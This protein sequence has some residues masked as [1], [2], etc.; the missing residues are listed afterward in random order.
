MLKRL[1]PED[2]HLLLNHGPV[3]LI[4][5]ADKKNNPNI[6]T[7]AWTGIVNSEPPLIAIGMGEQAYSLQSIKKSKEFVV[8]LP[9]RKLIKSVL[10]CGKISGKNRDKFSE[11]NLT[12]IKSKIVKS[13]KIKE[14]FAHIECRVANQY[15][16]G[17]VTLFISKILYADVDG[18]FFDG[19]LKTDKIKTLHHLG[20][21]W[22][23]ETGRRF[24]PTT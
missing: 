9:D 14:C 7:L 10:H 24:Y 21:G 22:F 4:S 15:K 23:A 2:A 1:K 5:T 11:T 6:M 12:P 20:G 13:P 19:Y 8:N 18:K 17:D 3:V 16:Y